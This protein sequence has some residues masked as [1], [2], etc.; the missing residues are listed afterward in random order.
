MRMSCRWVSGCFV[1]L[2]GSV[3]LGGDILAELF[4]LLINPL[5][6]DFALRWHRD[7]VRENATAD[8]EVAALGLWT[9]GVSSPG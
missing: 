8:E 1:G 5:E 7:D 3:D 4:N 6:H 2:T 9:H